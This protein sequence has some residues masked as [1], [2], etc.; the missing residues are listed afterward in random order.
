VITERYRIPD[1]WSGGS[2]NIFADRINQELGRPSITQ[3]NM[4]L[5]IP[6]PVY[7]E[8]T[9][10]IR[11]PGMPSIPAASGTL[12]DEATYFEY[13][14]DVSAGNVRLRYV[15]RTLKD[16]L[17]A[18][19]VAPHL[20]LMAKIRNA[21]S[22]RVSP[23]YASSQPEEVGDAAIAVTIGILAMT[24][25]I[26]AVVLGTRR[27]KSIRR[28]RQLRGRS[29]IVEG[30]GPENPLNIV[31]EEGLGPV[32]QSLR[33]RCGAAYRLEECPPTRQGL[34]YDGRRLIAVTLACNTCGAPRDAYFAP[35]NPS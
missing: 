9:I 2:R 25:I 13:K 1:F 27:G 31:S 15:Y 28:V 23:V 34:I 6:Y 4:P 14:I 18:T 29:K 20:E 5:A 17:D 11:L 8:Q 33:C 22:Q 19:R 7:V 16:H 12:S 21:L 32:L 3:R 24:V 26:I 30:E 10:D 35:S